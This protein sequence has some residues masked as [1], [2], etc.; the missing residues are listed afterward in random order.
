MPSKKKLLIEAL[1]KVIDD[2]YELA[3]NEFPTKGKIIITIDLDDKTHLVT[4]GDE[5]NPGAPYPP[6]PPKPV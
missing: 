3:E 4:Y 5:G 2:T 1:R 6:Q